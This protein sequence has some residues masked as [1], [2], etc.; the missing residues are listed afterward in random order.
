MLS[1]TCVPVSMKSRKIRNYCDPLHDDGIEAHTPTN[2]D[3]DITGAARDMTGL[4]GSLRHLEL[5]HSSGN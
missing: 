3:S 5:V 2:G 4:V 1:L